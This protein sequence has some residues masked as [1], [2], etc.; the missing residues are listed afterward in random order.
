MRRENGG[1]LSV[2]T[3]RWIRDWRYLFELT[4]QLEEERSLVS[5]KIGAAIVLATR[6]EAKFVYVTGN[7]HRFVNPGHR[8]RR[9]GMAGADA[10]GKSGGL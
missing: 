6:D 7:V 8:R 3:D 2:A 4:L 1:R 5:L 9:S 10:E